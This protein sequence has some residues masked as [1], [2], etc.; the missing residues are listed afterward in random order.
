YAAQ[1]GNI[2]MVM[3]LLQAAKDKEQ[4]LDLQIALN[5]AAEKGH[6]RV[7]EILVNA[8][9]DVNARGPDGR[10]ALMQAVTSDQIDVIET[11]IKAGPQSEPT[12]QHGLTAY[13]LAVS[14][15]KNNAKTFLSRY[16]SVPVRAEKGST[17]AKSAG[18]H[19]DG[20]AYTRVNGHSLEV[21]EG[22]GLA[23]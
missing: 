7:I 21:Q 14:Q 4:K 17:P 1:R 2:R 12:D 5:A 6:S 22:G 8:G 23:L 20:T 9:A 18:A 16:R 11:L 3:T 13:D 15:R 19:D 10:T